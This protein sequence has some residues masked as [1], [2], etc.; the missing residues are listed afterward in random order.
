MSH[1]NTDINPPQ[2]QSLACHF[3]I[4]GWNGLGKYSTLAEKTAQSGLASPYYVSLH[5]CLKFQLNVN[6]P[7]MSPLTCIV[8]IFL[9]VRGALIFPSLSSTSAFLWVYLVARPLSSIHQEASLGYPYPW[10]LHPVRKSSVE[11]GIRPEV[12]SCL[13]HLE[14]MPPE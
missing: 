13:C 10:A 6:C 12:E 7:I 4:Q 9:P 11:P 2:M 3:L 8:H 5:S 1:L 14:T